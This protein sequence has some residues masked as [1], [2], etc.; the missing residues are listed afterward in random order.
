[1]G[2]SAENESKTMSEE[3]RSMF[4]GKKI[5]VAGACGGIGS[6]IT[7]LLAEKGAIVILLGQS[8]EKLLIQKKRLHGEGHTFYVCGLSEVENIET[9]IDKIVSD[10]GAIDGFV[11]S[12]GTGAV[13][14]L[15][16]SKYQ[17]MLEVMNINFFAFVEMVRCLTK[18]GKY[19][20][21]MNIVGISS[22]GA[23]Y[24]KPT[25]V[26]YSASKGAMDAAMRC[27]AIELA[28]KNIRVN[29]VAPGT[30]KTKMIE[31]YKEYAEG[32][33]GYKQNLIRQ[34]LGE[35]LPNDIANAALFLLSEESRMI[36]G[37]VLNVD[38]GKMSS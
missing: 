25:R 31:E 26:A 32:T 29:V 13:R 30:T 34:Y 14:P 3:T 18:K 38:G 5:V 9:L 33:D 7:E 28:P 17:F 23:Q 27:M 21:G 10:V 37:T 1:L 11:Y 36:T 19:N 2:F 4:V 24:G 35:C 22:V 12:A 20:D 8:E 15:K 16:M 6:A